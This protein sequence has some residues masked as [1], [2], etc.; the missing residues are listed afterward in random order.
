MTLCVLLTCK[1]LLLSFSLNSY[2]K[3]EKKHA[4]TGQEVSVMQA[5]NEKYMTDEETNSDDED[6]TTLV[7]HSLPWR[8]AKCDRFLRTLDD[9]HAESREK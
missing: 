5:L 3:G 6:R 7:K 9:R 4:L 2:M 8:S 1:L